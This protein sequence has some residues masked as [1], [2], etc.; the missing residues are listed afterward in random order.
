MTTNKRIISVYKNVYETKI[1]IQVDVLKVLESIKNPKADVKKTLNRIRS[2]EKN[3]EQGLLKAQ[4]PSI[5]F[6][7]TFKERLD[8]KIIQH[9]GLAT[10]DFDNF[11]TLE[12]AIDFKKEIIKNDFIFSAFI[13]PSNKGVKAVVCVPAEKENYKKYYLALL[14]KFPTSKR[15][16]TS[17]NISRVC[18]ASWDNDI[19]INPDAINFN[20]KIETNKP[21]IRVNNKIK[22]NYN[23]INR[24]V[25]MIRQSA[26]GEK[27]IVLIRASKLM[28]GYIAGGYV[29]EQDAIEIL[30]KEIKDK[31]IDNFSGAC[32]DIQAGIEYGKGQPI[33]ELENEFLKPKVKIQSNGIIRLNDVWD[34]MKYEFSH[35]KPRGTTT[36][37]KEL[38]EHWTW[39]KNTINLF[40]GR[41]GH[42]KSQFVTQLMLIKSVKEG[43][44]WGCF[45]PESYPA[46][47]FYDD[48]IH[49]YTGKSVDQRYNNHM[50]FNEYERVKEFIHEHFFFVYPEENHTVE[51]IDAYFQE[52]KDKHDISGTLID[53]FNQMSFDLGA[54]DDEFLRNFLRER[55]RFDNKNNLYDLIVHHGKRKSSAKSEGGYVHLETEDIA[56]G[57][58]WTNK[59]DC[60]IC[61]H[62]PNYKSDP[63]DNSTEIHVLK[64]KSHKRI[65]V[66]GCT[67][68]TYDSAKSRYYWAMNNPLDDMNDVKQTEIEAIKPNA[69]FSE[70][71]HEQSE[72]F[73]YK[74]NT[75]EAPPF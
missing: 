54:R 70:P 52:L 22:T 30:Q 38:D 26:D 45:S 59:C 24:A 32:K 71:L 34:K 56:N 55:K 12:Q 68:M 42:G 29:A 20:E 14:Q 15:D 10:L 16:D 3:K 1:C 60:I 49:S 63:T 41:G 4:L 28:G 67:Y 27:H 53:P 62:R 35:G 11:E 21:E 48:L 66:P 19:Y 69:N 31:N 57:E 18:Y 47:D 36:Y 25:N 23:Y 58:M 50:N 6:S 73:E 9:S 61:Y 8:N 5:C 33:I 37:F 40:F 75:G 2:M 44:K 65:G 17:Q 64:T 51:V 43:D 74:L 13:S 39:K 7:G 72:E 46:E